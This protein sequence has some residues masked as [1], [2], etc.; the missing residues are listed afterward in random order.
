[1]RTASYCTE[2]EGTPVE[3]WRSEM[4]LYRYDPSWFGLATPD[5]MTLESVC[6][7]YDGSPFSD[8]SPR[9]LAIYRKS[10]SLS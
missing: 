9:L 5:R 8:L 2:N 3:T 7:D 1:L 10:N 6:G 4:R